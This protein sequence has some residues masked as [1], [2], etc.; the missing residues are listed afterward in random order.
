MSVSSAPVVLTSG[1]ATALGQVLAKKLG[2][3]GCVLVLVDLEQ[4]PWEGETDA[5]SIGN[6][7]L[8]LPD[9]AQAVVEQA[10]DYFGAVDAL[11]NLAFGPLEKAFNLCE[12]ILPCFEQQRGGVVINVGSSANQANL[13]ALTL[14][15]ANRCKSFGVDAQAMQC[16]VNP[17]DLSSLEVF[18]DAL[19]GLLTVSLNPTE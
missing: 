7:D 3:L 1:A 9:H 4:P 11:V 17:T 13:S 8:L 2:L 15:F 10:L 12:A 6:V 5:V 14:S 19:T 18:S 16:D